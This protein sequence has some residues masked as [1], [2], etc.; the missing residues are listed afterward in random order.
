MKV[1][2][3]ERKRSEIKFVE[4][5]E[6]K[7][8]DDYKK[9]PIVNRNQTIFVVGNRIYDSEGLICLLFAPPANLK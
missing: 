9:L 5:Y 7:S 2:L 8:I 6:L 3:Y 1:A 4:E